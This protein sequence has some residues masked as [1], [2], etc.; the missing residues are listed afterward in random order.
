MNLALAHRPCDTWRDRVSPQHK[1][2]FEVIENDPRFREC[3]TFR[4]QCVYFQEN[5]PALSNNQVSLFLDLDRKTVWEQMRKAGK[6]SQPP[7]R[8]MMLSPE[9]QSSV[10]AFMQ[11]SFDNKDPATLNDVLNFLVEN[12]ERDIIPDSLRKWINTHTP[13]HTCRSTAMEDKRVAVDVRDISSYLDTLDSAVRGVPAKFIFNLDESGFQKYCDNR[14]ATILVPRDCDWHHHP[15]ARDEKRATFLGVIS[16]S[17]D[18][19]RPLVVLPRVTIEAE[20]FTT[21]YTTDH[22]AYAHSRKGFIT[23]DLFCQYLEH[24]FIPHV[25][26]ERHR[27][28]YQGR[29]VLLM[30]NCSCHKSDA[31]KRILEAN[32]VVTVFLP[33]HSSDQTQPLDVGLFGNMKM[34]QSRIHCPKRMSTQSQQVVKMISAY[35]SAG[36][37]LAVTGAF[38]RAG[39]TNYV[40]GSVV[41]CRVTRGT[42]TAVRDRPD[43]WSNDVVDRLEKRKISIEHGLWPEPEDK[44]IPQMVPAHS[45]S[46]MNRAVRQELP[47]P[48]I[49]PGIPLSQSQSVQGT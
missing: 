32:N 26:F 29:A 16:A 12:H 3:Q 30:D 5:H 25:R 47:V 8:P 37:P 13:F 31:V 35:Y 28:G 17:G 45:A 4:D 21:G 15:V 2:A 42:C 40:D 18:R 19:L 49:F 6:P 23:T 11:E 33:P 46:D 38:V 7:G 27:V 44:L 43:E 48:C 39:L 36:H 41:Y 34:A 22:V 10:I 20:L 9:E 14:F 1:A 24:V